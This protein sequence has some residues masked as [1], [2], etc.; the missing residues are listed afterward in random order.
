VLVVG[1]EATV[2]ANTVPR[3]HKSFFEFITGQHADSCF[4]IKENLESTEL[5]LACFR[6]MK[7]ELRFDICQ[8]ETS[9]LRNEDFPNLA[10]RIQQNI[11]KHLSYSCR[12]WSNHL[13]DAASEDRVFAEVRDFLYSR[14]LHWL[15]VL[16][17]IKEVPTAVGSLVSATQWVQVEFLYCIM[18]NRV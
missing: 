4:R 17:L 9:H 8:L 2:D 15:E 11:S 7:S 16:S 18:S 6:V 12:F 1:P 5:A 3:L 10:S 14:I 13:K